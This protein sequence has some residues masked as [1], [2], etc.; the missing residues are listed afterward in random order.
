[1]CNGAVPIG[2]AAVLCTLN[3]LFCHF[4][5]SGSFSLRS[6][7]LG[8]KF[9]NGMMKLLNNFL[10]SSRQ[11]RDVRGIVILRLFFSMPTSCASFFGGSSIDSDLVSTDKI[12]LSANADMVS[13]MDAVPGVA[14][15]DFLEP[16]TVCLVSLTNVSSLSVS[17]ALSELGVRSGRILEVSLGGGSNAYFGCG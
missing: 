6:I 14:V 11:R 12:R 10:V 15:T 9:D 13:P 16:A 4:H 1:M 8:S 17:K 7:E 3:R 2:A 5:S